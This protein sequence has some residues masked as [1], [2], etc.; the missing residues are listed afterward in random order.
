MKTGSIEGEL[1]LPVNGVAATQNCLEN[2]KSF[3][4]E[5]RISVNRTVSSRMVFL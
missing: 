1:R 3:L 4:W 2:M 5:Y